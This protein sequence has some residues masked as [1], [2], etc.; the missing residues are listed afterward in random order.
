MHLSLF[1]ESYCY[2]LTNSINSGIPI[3]YLDRG[4][5]GERLGKKD[6]YFGCDINNIE[7][8]LISAIEY[9]I[10]QNGSDFY[11]EINNNIQPA[12]WYLENY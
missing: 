12:R 6:K 11:Y 2:A 1:E 5:F 4:A 9:I 7:E 10:K 8:T 3:I